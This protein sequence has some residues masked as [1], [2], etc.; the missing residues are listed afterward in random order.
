MSGQ[1]SDLS[2]SKYGYDLVVATT[3]ASINVTMK[4]FLSGLD[5]SDFNACY[6]WDDNDNCIPLDYS[7]VLT[8]T[9][10]VARAHAPCRCPA[11]RVKTS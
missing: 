5:S 6:Q 8:A 3:Q 1:K 10:G 4:E 11:C 9:G 7:Q 2:T